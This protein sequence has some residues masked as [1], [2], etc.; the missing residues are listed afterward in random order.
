MD[1]CDP[2]AIEAALRIY[3]GRAM[4]NS[5]SGEKSKLKKLLPLVAQYG[6][7]FILLPLDDQGIPAEFKARRAIIDFV[8]RQ[9]AKLGITPQDVVVDGLALA[10]SAEPE[11]PA[12]ALETIKW[13]QGQGLLTSV[14]LSNVS[15]GLP[16]RQWLNSAFLAQASSHGLTMAIMNPAS[17]ET[18]N[19]RLAADVLSGRDKDAG[20]Y[21]ARFSAPQA[22]P[23]SPAALSVQDKISV[24]ILE[25]GRNAL[26]PL[27]DADLAAGARPRDI[28][29]SV[30]IPA[31]TRAGEL[32]ESRQY[33]LPQLVAAAETMEGGVKHLKPLLEKGSRDTGAGLVILATVEGDIHDIGK[34]I[35]ALILRN[36]GF[37]VVDLG[38]DVPAARIVK[39][40]FGQPGAVVGLSALMT[41]TMAKM[42]D[43]ISLVRSR[44]CRCKFI[45][46]G[47]V[48]N[49]DY[50]A[51]LGAAFAKDGVEAVKVI[52]SL[53]NDK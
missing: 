41:T 37:R 50:A 30:M 35:V 51:S 38:R 1:T 36:H 24:C 23:Q 4:I 45:L 16:Q 6:A 19:I 48:L 10:V 27:L 47:A 29:D 49:K 33:F 12:A 5:I 9:A 53:I 28:I 43:V 7:M 14:G 17:L 13:C 22:K 52:K 8:L 39:E 25:G 15:F 11:G 34:N 21:L 26:I 32:F 20:Q 31:I 44:G 3:P 46:G 42:K 2:K 40:A 18:A